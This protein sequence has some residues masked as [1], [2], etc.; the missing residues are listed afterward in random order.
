LNVSTS[1]NRITTRGYS[2]DSSGNLTND[3]VHTYGFNAEGRIKTVDGNTAYVYD[4]EGKR[5][6]KLVSENTRFI[7]GIGGE[8]LAEYDGSSGNLKKE[9]VAGRGSMI[10]I[11]PTGVNSN[12][13]QYA[14]TDHLGSPR[15]ITNSSG[16]VVSR[17][18]YMPFGTELGAGVGGRTTGIGFSGSGDRNRKKFTGYERDSGW[19]G[20]CA[21]EVFRF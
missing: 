20:L 16:S 10:T 12:G 7:Y 15:V 8:L 17:H 4:G 14:T 3:T 5:V 9:Y 21:S 6:K 18:D 13:T 1:T 19:I 11:E 2:Y